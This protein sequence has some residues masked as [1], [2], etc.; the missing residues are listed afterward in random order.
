[1][2]FYLKDNQRS[3]VQYATSLQSCV[4]DNVQG[5]KDSCTVNNEVV[6]GFEGDYCMNLCK[7]TEGTIA[8][9]IEQKKKNL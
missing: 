1:M 9:V 2:E 7:E 8:K 6:K 4:K 5:C 3:F